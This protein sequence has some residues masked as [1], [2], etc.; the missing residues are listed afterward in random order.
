[1]LLYLL[2]I[3]EI[4]NLLTHLLQNSVISL[5]FC[6]LSHRK[7]REFSSTNRL[8]L[9]GTPLQNNMT[10]LWSLLNFILPTIVT[11]LALFESWFDPTLLDSSNVKEKIVEAEE[12]DQIIT[13]LH[14]VEMPDIVT[15]DILFNLIKL[16]FNSKFFV[17]MYFTI[18]SETLFATSCKVR[19]W[20]RS[21]PQ[22]GNCCICTND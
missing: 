9:T 7:L 5:K 18:D 15:M 4:F 12:K 6:F 19:C 8:L 20:L 2:I 21:A 17:C 1:M 11:D 14:K 10:E 3:S 13:T 22:K 16:Q